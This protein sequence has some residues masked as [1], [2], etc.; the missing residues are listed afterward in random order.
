MSVTGGI[1]G[2]GSSHLI[3]VENEKG[4]RQREKTSSVPLVTLVGTGGAT[5]PERT[6][7]YPLLRA[8]RIFF[9]FDLAFF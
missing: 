8:S 6:N 1:G 4:R 2:K 9:L 5:L 3:D 7:A